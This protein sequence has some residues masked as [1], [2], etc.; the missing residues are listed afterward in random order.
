MHGLTVQCSQVSSPANVPHHA[1]IL[2]TSLAVQIYFLFGQDRRWVHPVYIA[3]NCGPCLLCHDAHTTQFFLSNLDTSCG[4]E[5]GLNTA[6]L[7]RAVPG[8]PS[9]PPVLPKSF[10]DPRWLAEVPQLLHCTPQVRRSPGLAQRIQL[11]ALALAPIHGLPSNFT[12]QHIPIV[13]FSVS[14]EHSTAI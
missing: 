1:A 11:Q 6:C 5:V 8:V 12:K 14:A 10:R 2:Q 3:G 9:G 7:E 13:F 4:V